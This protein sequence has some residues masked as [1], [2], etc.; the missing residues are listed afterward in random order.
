MS[1]CPRISRAGNGNGNRFGE[2]GLSSFVNPSNLKAIL[3]DRFLGSSI[4]FR[5]PLFP[6]QIL[7]FLVHFVAYIVDFR[8]LSHGVIARK[9]EGLTK[10]CQTAHFGDSLASCPRF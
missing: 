2:R 6:G 1:S 9:P 7:I 8:H 5:N 3:A 10:Q 4:H